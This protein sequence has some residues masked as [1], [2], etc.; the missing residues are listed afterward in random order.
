MWSWVFPLNTTEISINESRCYQDSYRK[1]IL[2]RLISA[3]ES[4]KPIENVI[5]LCISE[6]AKV[7][8]NDVS[9]L[10]IKNCFI[11]AGFSKKNC[12][13]RSS[14]TANCRM[15]EPVALKQA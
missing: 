11:K 14:C 6:I 10:K 5:E 1:K 12:Y 2:K 4:D 15:L 7:W 3:L 9:E 13:E 8:E